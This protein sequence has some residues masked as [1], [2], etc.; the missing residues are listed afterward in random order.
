MFTLTVTPAGPCLSV[1]DQMIL[2][3]SNSALA[4]AGPD[5]TICSGTQFTLA[6]ATAT[7]Y[8]SLTWTTSGTGTF[9]DPHILHPIYTASLVDILT[10]QVVLTLTVDPVQPCPPVTSH[11]TLTLSG[12]PVADAGPD[13]STCPGVAFTIG[14][15]SAAHYSHLLW[16][17]TGLGILTG[18]TT[19]TPTYT[20]GAGETGSVTLTLTVYGI[21]AC[22]STTGSDQVVILIYQN[23]VTNAG[24]DQS[25]PYNTS[26]ILS[27]T[28]IG[29]TGVYAF[30]WEPSALLLGYT[31]EHPVTVN[32]TSNVT[33]VLTVTDL[34]T[35]CKSSDSVNV[36]IGYHNL[37]PVAVN[38][39]D[40]IGIN[41]SVRI[42][43]LKNDHDPDDSIISLN[44]IR[45][46]IHGMVVVNG[47]LM[48][49]YTPDRD[50]TG[51]DSLWY[52]ICDNGIPSLCDT[53]TVYIYISSLSAADFLRIY[54]V[55]TPNEDGINDSWIIEGIEEY[56]DNSVEIFNRWGDLIVRIG[57]Y[58]NK[59]QVWKG[60]SRNGGRVPDGT[61]YYILTINGGGHRTGWILVR[62]SNR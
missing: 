43:S 50:Y 35:G 44:I 29:G 16:T 14:G 46:P 23:V 41:S 17:T 42:N 52:V 51:V 53:A 12:I 7:N 45:N 15:A 3:I 27:G 22:S 47:D 48:L 28:A 30:T 2:T 60:R 33:F 57:N 19:L 61:Y 38:D 18:D 54:N 26:T 4:F 31:T 39:Y 37:P 6:G 5:T 8:Q 49:R 56:P 40:T 36:V 59:T 10:G 32:M 13:G 21:A 1:T 62:G 11:M 55:I 58:D 25:I 34:V 20:P 24:P 9:N